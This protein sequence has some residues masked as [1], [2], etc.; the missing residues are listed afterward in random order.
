M[1]GS[2]YFTARYFD[3]RYWSA[4]GAAD[5][6]RVLIVAVAD[7]RPLAKVRPPVLA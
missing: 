4:F 7:T 1:W 3:A 5:A 6:V 2:R